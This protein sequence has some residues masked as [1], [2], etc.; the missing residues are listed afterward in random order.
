MPRTIV[1]ALVAVLA[2]LA[3][4]CSSGP[5]AGTSTAPSRPATSGATSAPAGSGSGSGPSPL[6]QKVR[7]W[8]DQVNPAFAKIQTDTTAITAA[9]GKQDL[10]AVQQ[11]C[12]T[13]RADVV[14]AS[15]GP[16][17]PY[18]QL[19]TATANALHAYFAGAN[20]CLQGDLAGAADDLNQGGSYLDAAAAIMQGLS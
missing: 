1:A 15:N 19:A 9:A 18:K 4:G 14:A 20:A 17:A 16:V 13:L 11:A 5:P 2:V 12:T 7:D 8:Y 3:S 6:L 10:P